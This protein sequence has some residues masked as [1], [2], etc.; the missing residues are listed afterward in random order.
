MATVTSACTAGAMISFM[1]LAAAA[2]KETVEKQKDKMEAIPI[3]EEVKEADDLAV[4]KSEAYSQAVVWTNVPIIAKLC[5]LMATASMIGCF[6]LLVGFN[7][8]CF[9]EYD[10][11]YTISEH[12]GG[13]WY[14]L[15]RPLGRFALLLIVI[16][17]I[18]LAAF[19]AW[20]SVGS[21][22]IGRLYCDPDLLFVGLTNDCHFVS[23]TRGRPIRYWNRD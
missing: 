2:V 15:V 6:F 4:Q 17:T 5:L 19:K 1:M 18:L 12:L 14:N 16:A 23:I 3:D 13:K 22:S 21:M 8:H 11:M 7:T 9:T 20:A 10:L